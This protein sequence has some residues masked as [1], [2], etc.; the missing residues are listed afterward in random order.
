[1]PVDNNTPE[2]IPTVRPSAV[3]IVFPPDTR[4]RVTPTTPFPYL[5]IGQLSMTFQGKRY[6]GTGV[7][8]GETRVLT[9]AHN[10]F[11]RALGGWAR[12]VTFTAARDGTVRPYP[13]VAAAR[14]HVPDAWQ[15]GP[16]GGPLAG[17]AIEPHRRYDYGLVILKTAPHKDGTLGVS[18]E[19]DQTL[20]HLEVN[21]TGYPGDKAPP[22]TM[23]G[24]S[25]QLRSVLPDFLTYRIST[26]QGQSGAGV[27][28]RVEARPHSLSVVGVHIGST[29]TGTPDAANVAVR[30]TDS[31]LRDLLAWSSDKP[32]ALTTPEEAAPA[33]IEPA[34]PAA[35]PA[36]P[37]P[38]SPCPANDPLTW[39][40]G[41]PDGK[42]PFDGLRINVKPVY[43]D[44]DE[45]TSMTVTVTDFSASPKGHAS[46]YPATPAT[47][48][49]VTPSGDFTAEG[50]LSFTHLKGV[51]TDLV[52][53]LDSG[54]SFGPQGARQVV[55]GPIL[56][57]PLVKTTAT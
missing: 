49:K 48:V 51:P 56:G 26:F 44:D 6:T 31:V 25:G 1:M 29:G 54:F 4:A 22:D 19:S 32:A 41:D 55:E 46:P 15:A 40:S 8:I 43:N 2:P 30:I 52:V 21:I 42:S 17:E 53:L 36:P 10:L 38:T 9:A 45:L 39:C 34:E 11:D 57:V 3:E 20:Q 13:T 12:D 14:L 23:W 35:P 27:L 28:G 33:P 47:P 18:V 16:G 24:A 50:T 7:L 37:S 5:A